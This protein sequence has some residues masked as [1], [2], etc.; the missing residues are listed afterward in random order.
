MLVLM[1]KKL[2]KDGSKVKPVLFDMHKKEYYKLG[3]P[4]AKSW[5]I[6]KKLKKN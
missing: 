4:F 1:K 3:E 2:L 5:N 6:G